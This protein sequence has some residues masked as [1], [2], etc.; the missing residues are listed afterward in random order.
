VP[1][2]LPVIPFAAIEV[3]PANAEV[4]LDHSLVGLGRIELAPIPD[5]ALHELRF[6]AEGHTPRSLFFI[7]APPAGR[8]ILER[9]SRAAPTNHAVESPPVDTSASEAALAPVP[10]EDADDEREPAKRASR[11]RAA[12]PV[13]PQPAAPRPRAPAEPATPAKASEAKKGA[14]V[15]LIEART[16]RVQ[17]VE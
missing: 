10:A 9:A 15:Q 3:Q 11:R 16:P 14:Q 5:G 2:D 12:A 4:W 6:V 17:V 7:D 1:R 13:A 8:V